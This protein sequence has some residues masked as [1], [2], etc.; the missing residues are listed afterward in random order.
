[1]ACFRGGFLA[2]TAPPSIPFVSTSR[3]AQ[4]TGSSSIPRCGNK[5]ACSRN[6]FL[7]QASVCSGSSRNPPSKVPHGTLPPGSFKAS[8]FF[9]AFLICK[10]LQALNALQAFKALQAGKG[11]QALKALGFL[12]SFHKNCLWRSLLGKLCMPSELVFSLSLA[13]L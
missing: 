5:Q 6:R 12:Q 1:M 7:K 4:G 11:V 10:A 3:D 2:G 8:Q 13:C 9:W